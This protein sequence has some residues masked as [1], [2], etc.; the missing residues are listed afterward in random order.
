MILKRKPA[1]DGDEEIIQD[2]EP[3]RA[4][5]RKRL[6]LEKRRYKTHSSGTI[7][8]ETDTSSSDDEL[9][10]LTTGH[11]ET[12]SL[13]PFDSITPAKIAND[14]EE[15]CGL[16]IG[17]KS[18]EDVP[19]SSHGTHSQKMEE[20]ERK[21]ISGPLCSDT[22]TPRKSA[23]STSVS[24]TK[25]GSPIGTPQQPPP[26][27]QTD[28]ES[29]SDT[30]HRAKKLRKTIMRFS[31]NR[32]PVSHG[33]TTSCVPRK[34]SPQRV[35]E[36]PSGKS[37]SGIKN[38]KSSKEKENQAY[39]Y[40]TFSHKEL[41]RIL[42][43]VVCGLKWTI[44]KSV[45]SKVAH[46]RS[47]GKK[48]ELSEGTLHNMLLRELK[49]DEKVPEKQSTP[50]VSTTLLEDVVKKQTSIQSK[51]KRVPV[52]CTIKHVEETRN[53]ILNR[54]KLLLNY[55]SLTL[56]KNVEIGCLPCSAVGKEETGDSTTCTPV[57]EGRHAEDELIVFS[58]S[59]LAGGS[60]SCTLHVRDFS[61]VDSIGDEPPLT[62]ISV[63]S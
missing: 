23:I 10:E 30:D 21:L 57:D 24:E 50:E 6:K 13:T 63:D 37:R 19:S 56:P 16:E 25:A 15:A 17:L 3:E 36:E 39:S 48:R 18:L 27:E 8:I 7:K 12:G 62:Q 49:Q 58:R 40:L 55:S 45:A 32:V 47:C 5:A 43:C 31:Y 53:D 33:P 34:V 9:S 41:E 44:R 61:L 42:R 51:K 28:N 14:I 1:S 35:V 38:R 46:I 60:G 22:L 4:E 20:A 2:S 29:D 26:T 52:S 11:G 54:A 59:K